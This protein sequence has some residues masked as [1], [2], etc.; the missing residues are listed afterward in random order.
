MSWDVLVFNSIC[1]IDAIDE[2]EEVLTDIGTWQEFRQMLQQ[3]FPEASFDGNWCQIENGN[4]GLETS[5]GPP[6]EKTSNT[7]FHLYGPDAIYMVMALCQRYNWQAFDCSLDSILNLDN[8]EKNG[9]Q[10]FVT[11]LAQ[12]KQCT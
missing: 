11:Y 12:I 5:L 8:P 6:D 9:Y 2:I 7:I 10:N 3:Q 1:K 4:A